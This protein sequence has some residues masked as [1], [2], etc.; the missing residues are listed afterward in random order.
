MQ[1]NRTALTMPHPFSLEEISPTGVAEIE[2]LDLSHPLS[3]KQVDAIRQALLQFPVLVFRSQSLSKDQQAKFS[4]NFGELEGH[5]GK[6]SDGSTFPTVHTLTNLDAEGNLI[7]MDVA[8]LNYFWHTDKSYHAVPAFV[9]ILHAI[10]IPPSGGD[11]QYT[12]T[13]L[14]YEAL[15]PEMK[16]HLARL[17]VV[18][19]WVASRI[20]SG[21][22]PAT[23][24]QKR[25]RPAVTHPLVR[26]H[27]DTGQKALY[28][29]VHVSHINRVSNT[30]SKALLTEL[31]GHIGQEQ[32]VYTHRWRKGDVVM[33]DNRCL[34]HR[35]LP[36]Y[37]IARHPRILNR[38]VIV[39]SA[40]V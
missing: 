9:T 10:E 4:V 19:D 18:H 23:E 7:N 1:N 35:A 36:N 11:T 33:W 31:T 5:I 13:R 25:A 2:G 14:A 39:G 37:E 40:P 8:K 26:T 27:P 3:A 20:N 16:S 24:D 29:G 22:A 32:F 34:L 28:L 21:T 12:N 38:T 30:E 6:L 17:Q 15:P